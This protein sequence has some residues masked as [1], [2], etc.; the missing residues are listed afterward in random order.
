M[1][2][3]S[4]AAMLVSLVTGQPAAA[5]TMSLAQDNAIQTVE[6]ASP[7]PP[8]V[9]EAL[10]WSCESRGYGEDCARVLLG[11]LWI[12]SSNIYDAVGD[13]GRAQGYFQIHTRLHGISIDCAQDI[14]CAA[15]WTIG[16]LEQNGYPTYER[17]A[18]QCH[19]GCNAGNGYVDRAFRN[20]TRLWEQPLAIKQAAP[21]TL[22]N[23]IET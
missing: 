15:D 13:G 12:E 3:L 1:Q 20:G 8:T 23:A 4:T 9:Q 21:V 17:Y 6:T 16:Y 18:V 11:M 2:H 7:I 22:V 19:N 14:L 5:E 10:L